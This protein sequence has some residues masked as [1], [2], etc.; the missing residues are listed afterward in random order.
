MHHSEGRAMRGVEDSVVATVI[1]IAE[2]DVDA[3]DDGIRAR[4]GHASLRT[5]VA[6]PVDHAARA[7]ST[8][9]LTP[10]GAVQVC[11]LAKYDSRQSS[12]PSTSRLPMAC[13]ADGDPGSG[14]GAAVLRAACTVSDRPSGCAGPS[15]EPRGR[16]G[17]RMRLHH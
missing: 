5:N 13:Q 15:A 2:L 7:Q 17:A 4:F 6:I 14:A 16:H 8:D 3:L 11:R 1:G 12:R 9:A 10:E